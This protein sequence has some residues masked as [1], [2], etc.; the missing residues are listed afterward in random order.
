MTYQHEVIFY[1][2]DEFRY[3]FGVGTYIPVTRV[4]KPK[5]SQNGKNPSN[6]VWFG[7]ITV[8]MGFVAMPS[9]GSVSLSLLPIPYLCCHV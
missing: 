7:R 2:W 6:W 4:L 9:L 8:G 1:I 3:G 5:P